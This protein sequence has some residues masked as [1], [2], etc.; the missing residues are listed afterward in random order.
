MAVMRA[1]R[2][3]QKVPNL[4]KRTIMATV[5]NRAAEDSEKRVFASHFRS[6]GGA[7]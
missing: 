3:Q 5:K 4:G 2:A 7:T 1:Y 6:G